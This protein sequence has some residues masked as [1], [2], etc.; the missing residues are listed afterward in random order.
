LRIHGLPIMCVTSSPVVRIATNRDVDG[1]CVPL[2]VEVVLEDGAGHLAVDGGDGESGFQRGGLHG[3]A[4][5]VALNV[6]GAAA[7]PFAVGLGREDVDANAAQLARPDVGRRA[8][9][10]RQEQLAA[11]RGPR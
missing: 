8:A 3:P 2:V 10:P 7:P 1:L 5:P 9:A 4:R 11:L 6:I